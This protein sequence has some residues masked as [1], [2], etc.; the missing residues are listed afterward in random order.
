MKALMLKMKY[1]V[2]LMLIKDGQNRYSN[3]L[4]PAKISLLYTFHSDLVVFKKQKCLKNAKTGNKT[5]YLIL[6]ISL[7]YLMLSNQLLKVKSKDQEG[8]CD[9]FY[10]QKCYEN[11]LELEFL[12]QVNF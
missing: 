1:K 5:F 4:Q 6:C 12:F 3:I 7:A 11:K 10:L 2:S 8:T 9:G